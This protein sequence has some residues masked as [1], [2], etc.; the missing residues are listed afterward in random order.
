MTTTTLPRAQ[1]LALLQRLATDDVFR[2]TYEESPAAAL[3][4]AGIPSELVDSLEATSVAPTTLRP[5]E[6]F[7]RAYQQVRKEIAE[8]CLCH[9]PPAISLTT[10]GATRDKADDTTTSFSEP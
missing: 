7:E 2:K 4:S 9:R 6:V 1:A 10:G 5:K 8:V 3:K